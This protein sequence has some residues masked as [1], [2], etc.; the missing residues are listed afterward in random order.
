MTSAGEPR[1]RI[2]PSSTRALGISVSIDGFLP[3]MAGAA[4]GGAHCAATKSAP[5]L[6]SRR[7]ARRLTQVTVALR[8]NSDGSA[9]LSNATIDVRN[10]IPAIVSLDHAPGIDEAASLALSNL[11]RRSGGCR[12][13]GCPTRVSPSAPR[14]ARSD[15]DRV[16]SVS[17]ARTPWARL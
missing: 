9:A 14:H 10:V 12:H 6:R 8:V 1:R 2:A 4:Q 3:F 17:G 13:P 7:F 16:A 5:L 11:V 15:I